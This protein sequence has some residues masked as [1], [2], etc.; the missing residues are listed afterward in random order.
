MLIVLA[1]LPAFN[2]LPG[3]AADTQSSWT[4]VAPMPTAR[5]GF[6]IAVVSGKIYALGGLNEGNLPVST[7]E[8][9]LSLI[10]I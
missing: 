8:E 1:L 2:L 10:H 4:S 6:G 7:N 9:Y 5:G 3:K